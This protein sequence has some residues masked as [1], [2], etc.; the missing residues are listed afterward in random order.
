[1][2]AT[3][4]AAAKESCKSAGG[5]TPNRRPRQTPPSVL[6]VI[7]LPRDF[8]QEAGS[9]LDAEGGQ[10]MA[11]KHMY[12]MHS[13]ILHGSKLMQLDQNRAFGWDPPWRNEWELHAE[14]WNLL[15][16]AARNW[17]RSPPTE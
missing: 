10:T 16:I 13:G 1:M 6:E 4:M 15:R 8:G 2:L 5:L 14:L 7:V 11:P 12:A 9:R 17:L 3:G